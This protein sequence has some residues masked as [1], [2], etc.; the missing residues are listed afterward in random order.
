[1]IYKLLSLIVYNAYKEVVTVAS[2]LKRPTKAPDYAKLGFDDDLLKKLKEFNRA[3]F[4]FYAKM[5]KTFW[6]TV[7]VSF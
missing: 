2:A 6:E 3:D 4:D 5:N 1:M 7:H